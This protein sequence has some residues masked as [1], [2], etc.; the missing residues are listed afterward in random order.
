M[1]PEAKQAAAKVKALQKQAKLEK[2]LM[3]DDYILKVVKQALEKEDD[4]AALWKGW[5]MYPQLICARQDGAKRRVPDQVT[6]RVE[7]R[8]SEREK[9]V[10]CARHR[11]QQGTHHDLSSLR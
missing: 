8:G 3:N 10:Q 11:E 7:A 1:S 9:T 2:L 5:S 6:Q 4:A